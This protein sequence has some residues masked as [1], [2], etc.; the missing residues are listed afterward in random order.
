[1]LPTTLEEAKGAVVEIQQHA[2]TTAL[3]EVAS[4]VVA[5]PAV[6][7]EGT[8]HRDYEPA[9]CVVSLPVNSWGIEVG[10]DDAD[11]ARAM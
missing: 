9:I 3:L 11:V 10:P 2:H 8:T 7:P 1:V 6:A 4:L 5:V